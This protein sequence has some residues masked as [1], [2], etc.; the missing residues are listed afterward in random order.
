M[1][2]KISHSIDD[3]ELAAHGVRYVEHVLPTYGYRQVFF[4]DPDGNTLELGEWP[5]PEQMFPKL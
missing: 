4:H 1:K 3:R 2:T 5:S